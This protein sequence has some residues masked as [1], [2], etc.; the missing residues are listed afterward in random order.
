MGKKDKNEK[1]KKTTKGEEDKDE[2]VLNPVAEEMPNASFD[3]EEPSEVR[4][5]PTA[6]PGAA[7]AS[8]AEQQHP[9]RAVAWLRER[10]GAGAEEEEEGQ[11]EEGQEGR[12][13]GVRRGG[14]GQEEEG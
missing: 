3:V 1:K 6:A 9:S 2:E 12:D 11:E 4:V 5:H 10:G 7:R 8:T 13:Q 14:A